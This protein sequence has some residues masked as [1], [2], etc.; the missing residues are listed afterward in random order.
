[1]QILR[2]WCAEVVGYLMK[3]KIY[4]GVNVYAVPEYSIVF[5]PII[6]DVVCC[7]FAGILA[8][9]GAGKRE[10]GSLIKNLAKLFRNIKK[11]NM[12]ALS[13]RSITPGQY[14]GG[15]QSFRRWKKPFSN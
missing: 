15:G 7:G 4:V 10:E 13:S 5:F 1:M 2:Q 14:L 12:K 8:I 3:W 11:N 6:P 9:K